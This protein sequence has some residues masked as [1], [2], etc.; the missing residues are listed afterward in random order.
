MNTLLKLP[1]ISREYSI[2]TLVDQLQK[3]VRARQKFN[4]LIDEWSTL[5][6]V[7]IKKTETHFYL[8]NG[9]N[10]VMIQNIHHVKI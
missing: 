8:K 7:I 6:I 4:E 2:C 3:H 10:A 1:E 5:L 9:K